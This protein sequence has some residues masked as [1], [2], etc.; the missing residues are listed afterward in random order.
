MCIDVDI[1]KEK[2]LCFNQIKYLNVVSI[3]PNHEMSRANR[4]KQGDKTF[5]TVMPM[6]GL[7]K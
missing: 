5:L 6:N 3:L 7:A 1:A 2:F 4:S